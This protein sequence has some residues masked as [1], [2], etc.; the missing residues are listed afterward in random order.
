MR[1]VRPSEVGRFEQL[2]DE[3]HFLG[4]RLYG[5]ALRYVATLDDEWVAL[6]GF[7]SAGPSLAA[8][9]AFVGWDEATKSRR[10]TCQTG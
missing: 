1:L 4:H 9:E 8:R 10:G 3:H 6:A 2:L 7:G 5:R